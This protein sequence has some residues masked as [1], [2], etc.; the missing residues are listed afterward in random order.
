MGDVAVKKMGV[1]LLAVASGFLLCWLWL[2]QHRERQTPAF[3]ESESDTITVW[4][5]ELIGSPDEA[6]YYELADLWNTTHPGVTMKVSVMSH[7]GYQSKLRVAIASGQ[8]PDVCMGGMETLDSLKYSGK[9]LDLAV[10][11]P[12]TYLSSAELKAMGPV[13]E[14]S[15]VRDGHATVFPIWRYCYGGVILAN[16]Q[17]LRD[18]G[19]DDEQ[20]RRDGWTFEQFREA[21]RKMTRDTNGDGTPDTWGF[22]AAAVHLNHLLI[23]EFGPGVWGRDVARRQFLAKD[24]ATGRWMLDPELA[25]EQIRQAFLLFDELLN[26]DK[27]WNPACLGM[28]WNDIIDELV[29]RRRIGMIFGETPW[30]AKLRREIWESNEALGA[31]QAGGPP[32]L[33]VIWMPTLRAGDR[34]APRAGVMG[35]SVLKQTPYRGDAHTENALRVARFLTHPVHLARSQIRQFRHLPPDPVRFGSIYPELLQAS[36][37][38]VKFYNSIMESD[39][40]LVPD[41]LPP[42]DPSTAQYTLVRSEMDRW[43]EREGIGYLEQVIYRKLTPNEAADKFYTSLRATVEEAAN[44]QP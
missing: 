22:G 28:T 34:S 24:P 26:E 25:V 19:F 12:E 7:A 16:R 31:K 2:G 17:M 23:N 10:P 21:C 42:N 14:R 1:G 29:V 33:T 20:I 27:T 36:D 39:L 32:D 11:I 9:A 4:V 41:P 43:L 35:F 38:W 30:V 3:P 15:I 8:P 37:P 6:Y 5:N 44:Q 40:P 18:A 13:V